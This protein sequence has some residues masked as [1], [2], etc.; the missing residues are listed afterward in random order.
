M[1]VDDEFRRNAA[2]AQ[3]RAREARTDEERA[4]W[5][6]LAEGWLALLQER[7]E[8]D[9]ETVDIADQ[10]GPTDSESLH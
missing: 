5:L 10:D 7:Q 2:E 8:E 9:E 6:Q 1:S 4:Y 3:Q